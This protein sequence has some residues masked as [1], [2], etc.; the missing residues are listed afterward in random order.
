MSKCM[1][2]RRELSH[3]IRDVLC[4]RCLYAIEVSG[5]GLYDDPEEQ[6]RPG[7]RPAMLA[8]AEIHGAASASIAE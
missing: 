8:A 1:S 5:D 3:T 2:C 7:I 4:L 6:T